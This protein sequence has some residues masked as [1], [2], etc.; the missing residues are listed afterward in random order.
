MIALAVLAGLGAVCLGG[1]LCWMKGYGDGFDACELRAEE[2]RR[3]EEE[4]LAIATQRAREKW[5]LSIVGHDG[6]RGDE[7][8]RDGAA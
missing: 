5:L 4:E 7:P 2:E 8:H 1:F 6:A 3:A